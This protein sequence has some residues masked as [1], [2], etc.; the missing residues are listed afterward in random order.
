MGPVHP[1]GPRGG[2]ACALPHPP[3][4]CLQGGGPVPSWWG[5]SS[6]APRGPAQAGILAAQDRLLD[7]PFLSCWSLARRHLS[8]RMALPSRTQTPTW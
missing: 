3:P 8:H 6:L 1:Q 2:G 4:A 7:A 5:H